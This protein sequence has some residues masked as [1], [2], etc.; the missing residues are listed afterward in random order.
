MSPWSSNAWLAI[1][2]A[3][4]DEELQLLE[5]LKRLLIQKMGQAATIQVAGLFV[6]MLAVWTCLALSQK[7]LDA[8]RGVSSLAAYEWR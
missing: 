3:T 5:A 8:T 2:A 7:C 4:E 6:L 1:A